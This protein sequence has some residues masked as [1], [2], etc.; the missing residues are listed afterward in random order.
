MSPQLETLRQQA[1]AH[2]LA[3]QYPGGLS[4]DTVDLLLDVVNRPMETKESRELEDVL[5]KDN[6]A[7]CSQLE[8]LRLRARTYILARQHPGGLGQEMVDMLLDAIEGMS[9]GEL[10]G[11]EGEFAEEYTP[12]KSATTQSSSEDTENPN[13]PPNKPLP[14]TP[15]TLK[16]L[17]SEE[18]EEDYNNAEYRVGDLC[19]FPCI[20][21]PNEKT[22]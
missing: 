5:A 21:G 17:L 1:R 19:G 10:R 8:T 22:E 2:I 12:P 15:K 3:H 18:E 9:E 13:P 6:T 11:L 7:M 16:S 14:P 4:H 20:I